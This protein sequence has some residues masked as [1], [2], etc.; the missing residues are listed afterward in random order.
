M[1]KR[2]ANHSIILVRKTE[3]VT[4]SPGQEFDFTDDEIAEITLSNPDAL[5]TEGTVDLAAADK[6]AK[7]SKAAKV[8]ADL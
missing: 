3:R 8:D 4:V 1:A 2:K 7:A 5:S 6:P